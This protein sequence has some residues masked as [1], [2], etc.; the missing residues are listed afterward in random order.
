MYHRHIQTSLSPLQICLN[1]PYQ[2]LFQITH[3]S[4]LQPPQDSQMVYKQAVF[5]P[6][7]TPLE[8]S[9]TNLRGHEAMK[10]LEPNGLW[11]V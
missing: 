3:L 4:Y 6:V 7:K 9:L 10:V 11:V 1:L 2:P 8:Q 5:F